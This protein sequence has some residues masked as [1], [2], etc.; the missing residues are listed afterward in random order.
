MSFGFKGWAA[1]QEFVEQD[2]QTPYVDVLVV[3]SSFHHLGRKVVQSSTKGVSSRCWRMNR[4]T[5]IGNL[6]LSVRSDQEIFWLDITVNN[7]FGVTKVESC[8]QIRNISRGSLLGKVSLLCQAFVELA[9]GRISE[10]Q[11]N[12]FRVVEVSVHSKD[13]AMSEMGLDFD[14]SSQLMFNAGL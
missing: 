11:I 2:S 1:V 4:P 9:T 5:E 3:V 6:H 8:C 13:V 10:N 12:S 7:V 14:F